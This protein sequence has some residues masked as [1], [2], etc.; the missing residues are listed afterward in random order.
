MKEF[1]LFF[2]YLFVLGLFLM[3]SSCQTLT[4]TAIVH[5]RAIPTQEQEESLQRIETLQG[6]SEREVYDLSEDWIARNF[7]SADDVVQLRDRESSRIVARGLASPAM[8]FGF[9]RPFMYT[10]IL[11]FQDERIRVRYEN[12]ESIIGGNTTGPDM[13]SQWD[14]V[15]EYLNERTDD[16]IASIQEGEMYDSW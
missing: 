14:R 11:D 5:E 15:A 8:D 2:K 9:E 4:M 12:L 7:Q 6:I 1:A 13:R 10:M 3:L 16:L